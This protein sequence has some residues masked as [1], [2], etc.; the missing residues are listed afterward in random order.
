MA[1]IHELKPRFQA[2]LR[3]MVGGLAR[4]GITANFVTLAALLLS[5]ATGAAIALSD[6]V[7]VL[8]ILPVVILM[9][10]ALNAIDHMLAREHDQE[11]RFGILFNEIADV[12]SDAALT[13]PIALHVASGLT[14]ALIAGA[15]A[16]GLI[17][18]CAG[19]A[20]LLVGSPRRHEGP[21]G[22]MDRAI[23][24]GLIG[25]IL[26]LGQ[27]P[28]SFWLDFALALMIVLALLTVLN[29]MRAALMD[30]R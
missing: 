7:R 6:D 5:V 20:A 17:V 9:R 26:G 30:G 4:A 28:G 29:R 15:V 12:I 13:L 16:A 18:E 25:L 23:A 10:M 14:A 21:M 19:L 8:L 3:P 22:K 1:S 24:F 2:V 27:S 11:N